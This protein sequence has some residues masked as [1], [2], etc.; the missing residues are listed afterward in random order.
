[1]NIITEIDEKL[2][3]TGYVSNPKISSAVAVA[4]TT[5]KPLLIEGAPGTGKTSLAKAYAEAYDYDFIRIQLYDGLT[6]DKILYDYDYQKQLLTLEAIR[7]QIERDYGKLSAKDAIHQVVNQLDFYGPDFLIKRPILRSITS[8]KKSV[9]LLDEIDKAPEEIEYMLYEF[10]E[11]FSITIP[12][13]GTIT[14]EEGKEPTVFITSNNYR[15]ISEPFRRRCAYLYIDKKTKDE[16]IDILKARC[17]IDIRLA[18][19]LAHCFTIIS[20][21]ENLKK[22]PSIA[23]LVD[24]ANY[25]RSDSS[26]QKD[27]VMN[28]LSL[29]TKDRRDEEVI[30]EIIERYGNEIWE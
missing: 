1:M 8:D 5:N 9:L 12:Q 14:S 11:H 15:D 19:G 28:S 16:I 10:L 29:L 7:P 17:N 4:E 22:Y 24:F 30:A 23:E 20:D 3:E 25:I 21:Q 26:I 6:D 2:K 27:F 18:S 13:Y